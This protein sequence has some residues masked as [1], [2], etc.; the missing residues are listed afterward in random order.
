MACSTAVAQPRQEI[1]SKTARERGPQSAGARVR[2]TCPGSEWKFQRQ[3]GVCRLHTPPTQ[4]HVRTHTQ[5][6]TFFATCL[7]FTILAHAARGLFT[8]LCHVFFRPFLRLSKGIHARTV[9]VFH[10]HIIIISGAASAENR[11]FSLRPLCSISTIITL[12]NSC[13]SAAKREHAEAG[14]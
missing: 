3:S 9:I 6:Q 14:V 4:R 12:H 11:P 10:T 5:V 13:L 8:N 2:V 1:G 7:T